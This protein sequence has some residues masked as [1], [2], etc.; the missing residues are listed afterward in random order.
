MYIGMFLKFGIQSEFGRNKT[1]HPIILSLHRK[2]TASSTKN[3][4][5]MANE[6]VQSLTPI[7]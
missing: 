4:T 3:S 7:S 2:G 6:I 5:N 1:A